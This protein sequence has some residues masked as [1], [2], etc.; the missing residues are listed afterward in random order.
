MKY[1]ISQYIRW[2]QGRCLRCGIRK[3]ENPLNVGILKCG[4]YYARHSWK[5]R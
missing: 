3:G 2:L 1:T 4:G 5:R